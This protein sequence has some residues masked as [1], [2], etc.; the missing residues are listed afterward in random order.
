M[1]A[2]LIEYHVAMAFHLSFMKICCEM[3]RFGNMPVKNIADLWNRK[4]FM[5]ET[6]RSFYEQ[7]LDCL[8]RYHFIIGKLETCDFSNE[9]SVPSKEISSMNIF[10][11]NTF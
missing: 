3:N 9:T 6:P 7:L 1:K 4:I 11:M 5:Q 2:D 8:R 10:Y